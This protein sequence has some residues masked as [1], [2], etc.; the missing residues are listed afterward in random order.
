MA[1]E[2]LVVDDSKVMREMM[3]A[4]LRGLDRPAFTFAAS[5]VEAIERLALKRFDVVLLDLNMPDVNGFEVLEF[6]RGNPALAALPVIVVTTRGDETSRDKALGAGATRF[7]VKPFEPD[8]ML[9]Q[10]RGVLAPAG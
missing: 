6:M 5:G 7:M 8:A 10:V 3:A 4:S 9:Q 1:L 2:V